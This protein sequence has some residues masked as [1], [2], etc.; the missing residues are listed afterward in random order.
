MQSASAVW[1]KSRT[2]FGG[3]ALSPFVFLSFGV[4]WF[5]LGLF[6]TTFPLSFVGRIKLIPANYQM[7]AEVNLNR[8]CDFYPLSSIRSKRSTKHACIFWLQKL[9]LEAKRNKPPAGSKLR[10]LGQRHQNHRAPLIQLLPNRFLERGTRIVVPPKPFVI[11]SKYTEAHFATLTV[12][13]CPTAF[14]LE[15]WWCPWGNKQI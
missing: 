3:Q 12:S 2:C 8:F 15:L 7:M 10:K 13:A 1:H 11:A 14:C 6:L 4:F 5:G 9:G